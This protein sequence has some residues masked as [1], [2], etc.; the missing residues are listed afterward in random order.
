MALTTYTAGEVLTAASLNSNFSFAAQS[1]G[2]V[3][4]A[5]TSV[6]KTGASS[7]ATAS[8]N[9]QVT[10]TLCETL[11]LNGVFTSAYSNYRIVFSGFASTGASLLARMSVGGTPSTAASYNRQQIVASNTALA[12]VRDTGATSWTVANN[13]NTTD[14]DN[15][16]M[17]IFNPQ[18]AKNTTLNVLSFSPA[19][20][21]YWQS[22][23]A[24]FTAATV[25]DGIQFFPST[26]NFSGTITVYGYNQ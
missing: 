14:G 18:A 23:G 15:F 10:F 26:G 24:Y 2:L 25:F 5:P 20:G 16:S 13:I 7:T 9:G 4:V 11:L 8:I 1:G 17:D 3:S 19:A 6:G 21:S 12:G 22:I